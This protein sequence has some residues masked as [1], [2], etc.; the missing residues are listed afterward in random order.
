MTSGP[1]SLSRETC[2]FIVLIALS[3]G[4]LLWL[5]QTGQAHHVWPFS[6]LGGCICWYTLVLGVPSAMTLTVVRLR[7]ARYWQNIAIVGVLLALL[8]AWAMW[9]ATGAPG[10]RSSEVLGPY[11]ATTILALF[12]ALPWL[13]C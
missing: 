1:Q 7:D 12:V 3:Q 2:S 13:Q 5:A 9:S 11:G 4:L 8:A 10:L 6:E